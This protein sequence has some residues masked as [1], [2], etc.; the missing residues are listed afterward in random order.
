M[1]RRIYNKK[2]LTKNGTL[3]DNWFEEEELRKRTWGNESNPPSKFS[4]KIH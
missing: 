2:L 3:I 1:Y 4:T